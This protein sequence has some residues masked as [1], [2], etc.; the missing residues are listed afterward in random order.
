MITSQQKAHFD[1][2]GF[3]VVRQ[4][5]SPEEVTV[6]TT[7]FEA[8]ML[9][10][11][12]GRPFD[13]Q[14]RQSISDW[15]RGRASVEFLASDERVHGPIEQLLGPGYEFQKGNDGNFYVGDT[16]WHADMGWD[17]HIPEGRNDPNRIDGPWKNHY[18]PSIK[19]AFY[20]DPVGKDT[21]C[22]RVIPGAHRSPYHEKFWSLH[23]DVPATVSSFDSVRPKLLEMWEQATGDPGSG[24]R[25]FSDPDMNHFKMAPRDIPSYPIESE[26]GDAVFFSH[27]MWHS[28]FGGKVGRRMFTLNFRSAQ[29]DDDGKGE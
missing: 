5:F 7:A 27:Q 19:V 26:P 14:K 23:M 21:G 11:R 20:L 13:G 6:I 8:A 22:L 24:E 25:F 4:M 18:V 12:G 16:G 29:S 3:L 28:S 1:T 9:E 2:F 15:F 10:D 17:P